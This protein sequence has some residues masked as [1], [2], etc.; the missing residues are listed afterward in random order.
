[1][2]GIISSLIAVLLVEIY[3]VLRRVLTDRPLRKVFSLSDRRRAI[4]VPKFPHVRYDGSRFGLL[5]TNDAIGLAHILAVMNKFKVPADILSSGLLPDDIPDDL[6]CIGGP[7]GN[8]VT[9]L[10]MRRY[11][12]GFIIHGKK[13]E[14]GGYNFEFSQCGGRTFIDDD[15]DGWAFIVKLSPVH[16]GLPGTIMLLWGHEDTGTAAAA[17]FASQYARKL[18]KLNQ[19]IFFVALVA[20]KKLGYRRIQ[21]DPIDL[22]RGRF[23]KSKTA[24]AE[25]PFGTNFLVR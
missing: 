22:S 9:E 3:H 6:V 11:C 1:M 24:I 4:I 5:A 25:W 2:A 8:R 19:D 7:D 16:T 21:L 13:L 18:S 20:S 14:D 23:K 10:Y 12:P 17:F 15:E